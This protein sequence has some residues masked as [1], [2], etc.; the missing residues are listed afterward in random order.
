MGFLYL[1]LGAQATEIPSNSDLNN[2]ITVGLFY[3]Q[4]KS[5]ASTI[6]NCPVSDAFKLEVTTINSNNSGSETARMQQ[7]LWTNTI[8][9]NEY[10]RLYRGSWSEWYKVVMEAV[11]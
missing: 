1:L 5:I 11:S 9:P 7:R 4:N 10:R 6:S 2:Y 3:T 8:I